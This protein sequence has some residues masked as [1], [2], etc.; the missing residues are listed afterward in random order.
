MIHRVQGRACEVSPSEVFEFFNLNGILDA[1]MCMMP[2]PSYEC[3]HE[4]HNVEKRLWRP[5][6][7]A[8][9][10]AQQRAAFLILSSKQPGAPDELVSPLVGLDGGGLKGV[11]ERRAYRLKTAFV[12]SLIK[13]DVFMKVLAW[14][15]NGDTRTINTTGHQHLGMTKLEFSGL[16]ALFCLPH[17]SSRGKFYKPSHFKYPNSITFFI[18]TTFF[19]I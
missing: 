14:Y 15:W 2:C 18:R 9:D 12:I 3:C 6:Q 13:L 5:E 10:P 1:C 17:N 11:A 8:K 7:D 16:E 19:S 4:D